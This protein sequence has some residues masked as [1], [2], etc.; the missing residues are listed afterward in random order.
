V[1][2]WEETLRKMVA[3]PEWKSENT[4]N[5]WVGNFMGAKES[6]AEYK[7]E[8]AELKEILT[9]LGLAK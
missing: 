2:F 6:A 8:Y 5:L 7:R 3:T 4:K 1:R 9:E